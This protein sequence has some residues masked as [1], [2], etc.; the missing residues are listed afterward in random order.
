MVFDQIYDIALGSDPIE[1]PV[2]T[3]ND[4][5]E[6]LQCQALLVA[7][8]DVKLNLTVACLKVE[9]ASALAFCSW[10]LH[11]KVLERDHIQEAFRRVLVQG[12]QQALALGELV[13]EMD[14]VSQILPGM[15]RESLTAWAMETASIFMALEKHALGV[16]AS[17]LMTSSTALLKSAPRYEHIISDD[18]FLKPLAKRTLIDNWTGFKKFKDAVVTLFKDL[19]QI[20]EDHGDF[21]M[22]A[23]LEEMF[24]EQ[25]TV[26]NAN[27]RLASKIVKLVSH[28]QI[29]TVL[30]G[31]G[32]KTD[33]SDVLANPASIQFA[34]V[35]K[36]LEAIIAK[37][38]PSTST[39]FK[40]KGAPSPVVDVD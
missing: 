36:A 40:R 16:A 10:N 26:A 8:S 23:P 3:A 6:G 7:K 28:V 32:Q 35:R 19:T 30:T 25:I 22:R 29:V 31:E 17:S 13:V 11:K 33:A 27:F 37:V 15:E 20:A 5:V 38:R 24:H 1:L 34:S 14:D 4:A 9:V 39:R 18:V 21:Q 2:E 12:S